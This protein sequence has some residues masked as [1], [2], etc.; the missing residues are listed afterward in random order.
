MSIISNEIINQS[1]N[2]VAFPMPI[3]MVLALT[4][5]AL[6]ILCLVNFATGIIRDRAINK[7]LRSKK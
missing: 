4:F 1:I 2:F 7:K 6:C 3:R 5:L